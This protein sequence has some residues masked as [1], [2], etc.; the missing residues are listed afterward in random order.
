ME[1][2]NTTSQQLLQSALLLPEADLAE[3]AAELIGSLD[4]ETGED[5]EAAWDEEIKRRIEE[6]DSGKVKMVPWE[7]ARKMIFGETDGPS[8]T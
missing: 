1:S 6:I 2:M 3:I 5:V 4:G 7:E 8:E